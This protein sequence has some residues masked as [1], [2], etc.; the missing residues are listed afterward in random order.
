MS[1]QTP[2]TLFPNMPYP[3][4]Y[5]PA[6]LTSPTPSVC[7]EPIYQLPVPD[8]S[9][10]SPTVQMRTNK[11]QL[12]NTTM[13][14]ACKRK[15]MGGMVPTR[16][17][18]MDMT[19]VFQPGFFADQVSDS[20][21][22]IMA[23]PISPHFQFSPYQIPQVN[24]VPFQYKVSINPAPC[25]WY[26]K[27][28]GHSQP[29]AQVKSY[30]QLERQHYEQDAKSI[31]S[32]SS[33]RTRQP[34]TSSKTELSP[35]MI[36]E[37]ERQTTGLKVAAYSVTQQTE[38]EVQ[39]EEKTMLMPPTFENT[40]QLIRTTKD[41]KKDRKKRDFTVRKQR[42]KVQQKN[43]SLHKTELCTHWT[44]TSA[45]KFK[46]KCYFAHGLEE[47]RKRTRVRNYKIQP[48]VDCPTEGG[49]CMFGTRCNYCH[50]G[51]AIRRAI[52]SSYFDIDYYNRLKRD[53]PNNE[54]PFGIFI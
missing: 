29:G 15:I 27:P 44:L 5:I 41:I 1:Y 24:A 46:G 26:E 37:N 22:S 20:E 47:L 7:S 42:K 33:G 34:S 32:S 4:G 12:L 10:A 35:S 11:I 30:S 39:D 9:C 2:S 25:Q 50:P 31:R 48:C 54:F 23:G 16:M 8:G 51:E 52:G 36:Y 13:T 49:R 19:N 6:G 14:D 43:K 3:L 53:F 28:V 40:K 21:G 18:P 38:S 17:E 45:C